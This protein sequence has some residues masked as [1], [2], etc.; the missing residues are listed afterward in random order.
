MFIKNKFFF[1]LV[2]TVKFVDFEWHYECGGHNTKFFVSL[3]KMNTKKNNSINKMLS[4]KH[5]LGDHKLTG[6]HA[7]KHKFCSNYSILMK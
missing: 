2:V 4:V 3:F 5:I 1:R 7:F 6:Q